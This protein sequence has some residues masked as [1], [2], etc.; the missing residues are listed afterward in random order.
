MSNMRMVMVSI[1]GNYGSSF[2]NLYIKAVFRLENK[3]EVR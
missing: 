2:V 1:N 3:I